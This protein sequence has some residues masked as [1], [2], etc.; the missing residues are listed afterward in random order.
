MTVFPPLP[1]APVTPE[2]LLDY[3]VACGFDAVIHEHEPL[4]TVDQSQE[5]RGT[6]AGG[7]T[8]NLFLKDKKGSLFLLTAQESSD[9]NLKTLHKLMGA[10]GRFSF[11]SAEK[12]EATLGLKPGA[13]SALGVINDREQQ[14]TFAIDQTLLEHEKINCHPLRNDATVTLLVSDLLALAEHCGHKPMIL[15]LGAE[16]AE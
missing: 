3:I 13:V 12:M 1:P 14:V 11:G 8:K 2:A 4:F 10:S 16:T 9:V 7:H 5:L 15:D 6:M